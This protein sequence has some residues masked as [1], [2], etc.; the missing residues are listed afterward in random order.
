MTCGKTKHWKATQAGHWIPQAQG[1]AC[2]FIEDNIWCQCYRCNINLGGNGPEYAAFMEKEVG[3]ERMEELRQLSK[4]TKHYS[5]SDYLAL[6][7][8]YKEKLKCL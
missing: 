4:T 2:R 1:D 7:I 8:Q 6:E 3:K 5:V